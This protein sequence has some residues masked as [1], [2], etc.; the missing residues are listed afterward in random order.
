MEFNNYLKESADRFNSLDKK[1][2]VRVITHMDT[3]GIC[4][5]AVISKA[6]IRE[7]RKFSITFVNYLTEDFIR[8][9]S[10]EPINNF[11]FMDLGTSQIHN[12]KKYLEKEGK[13]IF[14][15]D[16][17]FTRIGKEDKK[18]EEKIETTDNDNKSNDNNSSNNTEGCKVNCTCHINPTIFG[19]NGSKEVSGAGV[20][21]LFA[22]EMNEKNKD[23]AYLGI[24]G[25]IGDSQEHD[26]FEGLNIGILEDAVASK[27]IYVDKGIRLFGADNKPLYKVLKNSVDIY[28]PGVTGNDEKAIEMLESLGIEPRQKGRW[29]KLE[30]LDEEQIK[31]LVERI[32]S[33]K[34]FELEEKNKDVP[35]ENGENG[36][37]IA[38]PIETVKTADHTE[39][40]VYGNKYILAGANPEI[41]DLRELS[42]VLNSCGRMDKASVG[43]GMLLGDKKCLFRAIYTLKEYRGEILKGIKWVEAKKRSKKVIEDKGFM[44]IN[45]EENISPKILGI[46][47]SMISRNHQIE[48]GTYIMA[49]SKTEFNKKTKVSL[50]V[51]GNKTKVS[52]FKLLEK[53]VGKFDGECGGHHNAAGGIIDAKHEEQFIEASIDEFSKKAIEEFVE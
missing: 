5:A 7:K 19:I 1:D 40:S 34:I 31:K 9:L 23:L 15:L 35:C 10:N 37:S 18:K 36:E 3:D 44:I 32:S 14:V 12:I 41:R 51:A 11:I 16:H 27:K 38:K 49:L 8:A 29:T 4:A 26:G 13:Q 22:K 20:T 45:A 21:Y 39:R 2:T 25:A 30:D 46:I 6:L 42:T 17:H 48:T 47:T 50:R 43:M 53:M 52:L 28:I 33:R 24:V